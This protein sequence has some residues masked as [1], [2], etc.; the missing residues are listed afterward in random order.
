VLAKA[1]AM[2]Y[3][4]VLSALAALVLTAALG[5]IAYA[6]AQPPCLYADIRLDT[7]LS[8]DT[9][10]ICEAARPWADE[11]FR[12]FIFLT[13]YHPTS[14]KD[15]F[16]LLDKVEAEAGIYDPSQSDGFDKNALAL[17]ASTATDLSWAYSLTF[18]ERLFGTAL[19]TDEA[20]ARIK[21]QMRTAI[22][23]GDPTGA[24][25]QALDT[26]YRIYHPPPSPWG[27]VFVFILAV[28]VLG[29][30]GY[31]LTPRVI[32]P[33]VQRLRRRRKLQRQLETLRARTSNLLNA[34]AQLLQGDTP[35]ET[36]LYQIFSIYGGERYE[37]LHARVREWLR[38]SQ[39]A[40]N[41]AFD[42]RQKLI[43][44]A[45]QKKRPLEQ[46]VRDWEM[47][48]VTFVGNSER[49][50]TLTD[51]EL[52]TLLDPMLVLDREEADVQ[53]AEQLD[54]IRREL[55]GMPLKVELMMVDPA[56]TDA[57]GI[58]GYVDRVKGMI[59][60]LRE[61]QQEA[62]QRLTEV[63]AQRQAMKE[64]IPSPFA[65]TEEQLF[66]G[67][68]R[69]L[70]QAEEALEQELFL[71][72]VEHTDDARRGLETVQKIMAAAE[73]HERRQAEIEALTAQGYRP[74]RLEEDLREVEKDTRAIARAMN[75]GDYGAAAR[76]VEEL[77]ADS[78]RALTGAQEWVELHKR[79]EE[80]LR[81]MREEA[82][83]VAAYQANEAAPAWK[84]LQTYPRGNWK[85]IADD[86][87]QA[88]E[89]LQTLRDDVLDR[90]ARLNS[91]EEQKFAAAEQLLDQA[92]ADLAQAEGQLQAVVDRL[93]E[94]QEAEKHIQ[95]ALRQT[96]AALTKAETFRDK[97]DVKIGPKVDKQIEKAH[98]L[99]DKARRLAE[100]RNFLAA[101]KAQAE[102]REL[103]TAAY[104][105][106]SEQVR[107]I[108]ALQKEL[109]D[110]AKRAEKEIAR[111]QTEVKKLPSV[112]QTATMN[113]LVQQAARRLSKAK[114]A[115]AAVS[116][117]E[118]RDLAEALRKAIAAYKKAAELAEK[119]RQEIDNR[120]MQYEFGLEEARRAVQEAQRAIRRAKQSIRD[121]DAGGAGWAALERAQRALPATPLTPGLTLETLTRIRRQA[122]EALRY[123][124]QAERQ[125][126]E[127]AREAERR[128]R[129]RE[130][131]WDWGASSASFS[132]GG[133][134]RRPRSEGESRRSSSLG[135]S[136]RP[137]S[138]GTSRRP[139]SLGR[140]RRR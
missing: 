28:G 12:V 126:Q 17:E 116:G 69:D 4:Q 39:E 57:E 140:R 7:E 111:C 99:L 77:T 88:T 67:I 20:A 29:T 51:D 91:L 53:L 127:K 139:S 32:I 100:E 104:A 19:D 63:K 82:D 48:Y 35:E 16:A 90:I 114:R 113:K 70:A 81:I 21:S 26:A 46:Q 49:I 64:D 101:E 37:D 132:L 84:K 13:D 124:R 133:S 122:E 118:D 72:A 50:L 105:S 6:Q 41:D 137:S 86:V 5:M 27:R 75:A 45:V 23:A 44:P 134:S 106:A 61:A 56:K 76:W 3:R 96:E 131:I 112:A 130:R 83:Q 95:K 138:L 120:R 87:A 94:V 108:N 74:P 110:L 30:A 10:A 125:A 71:L 2:S 8:V 42:L 103:A 115:R 60:R 136:R 119:A 129:R 14:E 25:V 78:Q 54:G 9:Q 85:D 38:R 59:A 11:G 107:E 47:L 97:E 128:R 109:A 93:A 121:P 55:T 102:A 65:L 73:E 34:C 80:A 135:T 58:L 43:D 92:L 68:D 98:R 36:V 24:F 89:T 1:E 15:W 52:R 18:G 33:G 62:P 123:A 117:Q 40:L 31:V 22:A 66:E 79:N